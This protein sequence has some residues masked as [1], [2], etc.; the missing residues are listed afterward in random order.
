M[1]T[2]TNIAPGVAPTN[3]LK[4]LETW[5]AALVNKVAATP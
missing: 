3:F 5:F 2:L 1:R 4:K